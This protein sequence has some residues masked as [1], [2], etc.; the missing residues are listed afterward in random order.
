M[1]NNMCYFRNAV[2]VACTRCTDKV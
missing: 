2:V 1:P